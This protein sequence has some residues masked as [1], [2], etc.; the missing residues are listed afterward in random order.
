[1]AKEWAGLSDP[2]LKFRLVSNVTEA[3]GLRLHMFQW[4]AGP[5]LDETWARLGVDPAKV[6]TSSFVSVSADELPP[7]LV[8]EQA[9]VRFVVW[10][11]LPQAAR[12]AILRLNHGRMPAPV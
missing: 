5:E 3:G 11:R 6:S 10:S 12:E 2:R 1:M 4:R 9:G 7:D 8:T